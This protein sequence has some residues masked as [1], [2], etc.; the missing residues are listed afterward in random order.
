MI[1]YADLNAPNAQ[2]KTRVNDIARALAMLNDMNGDLNVS[3]VEF[4]DTPRASSKRGL[5]DEELEIQ[6]SFWSVKQFCDVRFIL[7][8]ELHAVGET[9]TKRRPG[10]CHLVGLPNFNAHV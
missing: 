5:A 1:G 4:P 8:F 6:T 3:V 2:S 7:P 9:L 10:F